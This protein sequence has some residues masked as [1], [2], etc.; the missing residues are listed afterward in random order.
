MKD[1][2]TFLSEMRS[3]SSEEV[4]SMWARCEELY[5]KKLWHQLTIQLDSLVKEPSM[6]TKLISIYTDFIADFEAKMDPLRLAQMG[7]AVVEKYS[8]PDDAIAFVE[9]LPDKVKMNN[10]AICLCKVMVG[11]VRL[12]KM[13]QQK[14][15][16]L[17]IEEVENLLDT[18]D[19]IS[20]VHSH[21]YLLASDLHKIQGKHALYYR[22]S[23]RYLG[24]TEVASLTKEEQANHAFHLALAAL[25]GDRIFNFGELLAHEVLQSLKGTEHAWL[26]DLLLAFNCGD[27]AKFRALKP[28]WT[29]QTDLAR[30]E[31]ILFQKVC[32]LCLMEMTFRREATQRQILF[33]EIATA[34]TLPVDHVEMLIMK[35]L[36][37]GL[38][39]GK[40]DGVAGS[41]SLT[42]VQPRVLDATQLGSMLDKIGGWVSSVG[43]MEVLIEN[44]AGEILT[45]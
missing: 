43:S 1:V 24:C 8:T 10:E 25:L 26:I 15:T 9:K 13:Q 12:H 38:V 14:E 45:Y 28:Q 2:N 5:N 37:Q 22:A 42:W 18:N 20:P 16:K 21:F 11:R 32:L 30:N 36:A 34:T 29:K 17:I 33:T 7:M 23:L 40:I 31:P 19:G 44:K 27:V 3:S 39:K 35:A 4:A 41:V 6:Q